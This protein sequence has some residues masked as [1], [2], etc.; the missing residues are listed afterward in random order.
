MLSFPN[1][2][3]TY[4]ASRQ[5]ICFWAYDSAFE[6]SFYVSCEALRRVAS[7]SCTDEA[8]MLQVFDTHRLRIHQTAAKVYSRQR[9]S[10]Y[11]LIP[12][13]F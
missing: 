12:T 6:V 10:Y 8:A 7:R 9:Q 1:P 3:R 13:D 2:S 5:C 11:I 4:D